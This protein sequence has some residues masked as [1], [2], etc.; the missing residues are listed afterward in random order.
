MSG[1]VPVAEAS[2]SILQPFRRGRCRR[3]YQPRQRASTVV[4][5]TPDGVK[6]SLPLARDRKR[7]VGK[8]ARAARRSRGVQWRGTLNGTMLN[9]QASQPC[10]M[11]GNRVCRPRRTYDRISRRTLYGNLGGVKGRR[12]VVVLACNSQMQWLVRKRRKATFDCQQIWSYTSS[13]MAPDKRGDKSKS[14]CLPPSHV[15]PPT[16]DRSMKRAVGAARKG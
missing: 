9:E 1:T 7:R 15:R 3:R 8:A 11:F 14:I 13:G 16:R 4:P 6:R 2:S 5:N 12:S 10:H